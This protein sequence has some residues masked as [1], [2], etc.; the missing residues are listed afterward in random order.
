MTPRRASRA[1]ARWSAV[2]AVEEAADVIWRAARAGDALHGIVGKAGERMRRAAR[3]F[4]NG[5][6]T[7]LSAT[8]ATP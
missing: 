7:R 1:S 4:T 5:V 2:Y 8:A 6:R 3:V